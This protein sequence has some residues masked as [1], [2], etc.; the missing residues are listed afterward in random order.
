[1]AKKC[2]ICSAEIEE[3]YGKIKGTMLKLLDAGKNSLIYVCSECQKD[4]G[5]IEKAKI[6]GA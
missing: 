5:W 4:S 3:I 1:M 2:I 6:K